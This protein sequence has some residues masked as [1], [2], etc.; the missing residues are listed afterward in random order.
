VILRDPIVWAP[1]HELT[2]RLFSAVLTGGS[3]LVLGVL[4]LPLTPL[5]GLPAGQQRIRTRR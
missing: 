3:A 5:L 1:T 4:L 2:S